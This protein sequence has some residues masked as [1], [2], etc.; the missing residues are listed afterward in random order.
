LNNLNGCSES[1]KSIAKKCGR[2]GYAFGLRAGNY[3]REGKLPAGW[4]LR[5]LVSLYQGL[6]RIN[7][8]AGRMSF[9]KI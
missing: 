2:H 4:R 9:V 7:P 1:L 8:T 3:P 6:H 5:F